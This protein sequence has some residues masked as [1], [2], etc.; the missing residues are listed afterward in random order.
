MTAFGML[1]SMRRLHG[2]GRD[3]RG[4]VVDAEGAMLGPDC[5]LVRCTPAGFRCLAPD[6][7][8]AIQT[9]VLGPGHEPEWLFEQTSRI[10]AALAN[11][12]T[13]LAQ[14]YGLRIPVGEFDNAT[15]RRLAATARLVKANFDP[16]QPRVPKG[17]PDAGQWI[18]TGASDVPLPSSGASEPGP[19]AAS[20]AG[21]DDGPSIEYTVRI[22][23]ERPASARERNSIVRRSAEWLRQA[24]ALGGAF[25][26]DP[27]AKAFFAALEATGWVIEYLAEIRSYLD[28][29]KSLA[30]LQDGVADRRPG[31]QIHHIVEGQYDSDHRL[32]NS[33]RFRNR[34]ETRENL[35]HIPKWRHVEISSWYSR[36]TKEYGGQSPRES[37]RGRGWDEQY[38]IGIDKL[39]EFG[40]LK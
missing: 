33:A 30:E 34:L 24:G 21:G 23:A 37:L 39:R 11:G 28:A 32:R 18:D 9:V 26:R 10:A 31:Y 16:N 17:E 8:D 6:E 29:P 19:E 7:A 14:I 25:A 3:S 5:L 13:A 20:E 1:E 12:D 40:V 4:I 27:R 22:P 2:R 38:Q 36:P 15:L 35:V